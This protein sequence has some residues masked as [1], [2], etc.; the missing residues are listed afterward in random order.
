MPELTPHIM[1]YHYNANIRRNKGKLDRE[2]RH[3][4]S[5]AESLPKFT[6]RHGKHNT[7][8]SKAGQYQKPEHQGPRRSAKTE[9]AEV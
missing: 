5:C 9:E 3:A 2:D 8:G 6:N 1:A 4:R 7:T